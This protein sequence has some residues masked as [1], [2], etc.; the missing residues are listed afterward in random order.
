MTELGPCR[1]FDVFDA[2]LLV[3]LVHVGVGTD[4]CVVVMALTDDVQYLARGT[5]SHHVT[6]D[7]PLLGRATVERLQTNSLPGL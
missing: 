6:F 7:G 5:V 3:L 1:L 4:L 2:P